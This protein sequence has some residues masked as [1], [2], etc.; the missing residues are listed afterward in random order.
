MYDTLLLKMS[1]GMI[2]P[3]RSLWLHPFANLDDELEHAY[4]KADLFEN[5]FRR[6]SQMWVQDQE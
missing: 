3:G 6:Q 4:E 5:V 1:A 2:L